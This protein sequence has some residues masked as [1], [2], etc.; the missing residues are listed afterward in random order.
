M[1]A[2][3]LIVIGLIA[4]VSACTDSTGP[5]PVDSGKGKLN[6]AVTELGSWIEDATLWVTPSLEDPVNRGQLESTIRSL[7][8]HLKAN[9]SDD[10]KSDIAYIRAIINSGSMDEFV[11][12]GAI[13]V[14]LVTVEEAMAN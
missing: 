11:S 6:P 9:K 14:A 4:V 2:G 5:E 10:I 1:R 3:K 8:G 12:L 7:A 13:E